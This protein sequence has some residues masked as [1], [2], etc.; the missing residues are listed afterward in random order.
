MKHFNLIEHINN[1]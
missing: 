1:N